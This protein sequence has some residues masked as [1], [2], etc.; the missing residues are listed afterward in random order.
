M[1]IDNA[2]TD[3]LSTDYWDTEHAA[4]GLLYLSINAGAFRLLVPPVQAA[5]IA[6]LRT[7]RIDGAAVTRGRWEGRYDCVEVLLDDGSDSPW[8]CH[9]TPES[10]DRLP[11]DDEIGRVVQ[12]AVWTRGNDGKPQKV[13][14]QVCTYRRAKVLPDLRPWKEV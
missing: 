6:E 10:L 4:R 12:L 13:L 8:A 5:M 7:M 3:I 14:Q 11:P 2:G 1:R 9:M